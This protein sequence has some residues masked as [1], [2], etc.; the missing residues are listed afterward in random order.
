M[1]LNDEE[2]AEEYK[3]MAPTLKRIF[4]EK[5]KFHSDYHE[6]FGVAANTRDLIQ[7]KLDKLHPLL[8]IQIAQE[9]MMTATP[10]EYV[11]NTYIY[12][13]CKKDQPN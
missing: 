2:I 10:S 4:R 13:W 7:L 6:Q 12:R 8:P 11:E 3:R 1:N 9:G 5:V